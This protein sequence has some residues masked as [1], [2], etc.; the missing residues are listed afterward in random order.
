MSVTPVVGSSTTR[1]DSS[2]TLVDSSAPVFC[3]QAVPAPQWWVPAPHGRTP[4]PHWWI[5][6]PQFSAAQGAKFF[7][8]KLRKHSHL[9]DGPTK[10]KSSRPPTGNLK[11]QFW[12][13]LPTR[14]Q[15]KVNFIIA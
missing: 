4:A 7:R 13:V 12:M 5:P 9:T 11:F 15:M 2:A 8:T 3:S 10:D 14:I 6:A 1:A